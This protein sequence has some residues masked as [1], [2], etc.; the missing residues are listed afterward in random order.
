MLLII[1]IYILKR[2]VRHIS[3]Q[4]TRCKE[5]SG[6]KNIDMTLI[7]KDIEALAVTIN[8]YITF[9]ENHKIDIEVR[10]RQ[11][12]DSIAS[13][14][15]DLRTPLTSIKGYHGLL[16]NTP[17]SKEDAE[18][19]D[20]IHKKVTMLETLINDF[21]ELSIYE[22]DT[23]QMDMKSVDLTAITT[24]VLME[25]YNMIHTS[26]IT[27]TAHIPNTPLYICGDRIA[28]E[29][30]IQN[31]ISNMLRYATHEALLTLKRENNK[32][33]LIMKNRAEEISEEVI[34]NM[35]DRFYK[36]DQSR[37]HK[38]TGLGLYIVKTLVDKMN[39]TVSARNCLD[40]FIEISIEFLI[41]EYKE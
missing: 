30:I 36:S 40:G 13:I 18:Y 10:E 20:I 12:K 32:I 26:A 41:D 27:F 16:K 23:Y 29:R 33:Y 31:L 2:E 1:Y 38:G 22:S 35:F 14:S 9:Q 5:G 34:R 11:L 17:F 7:D 25:H 37:S 6:K 28:C 19:M 15:H 3:K 24:E 39:G 21:F 8:E 4:L